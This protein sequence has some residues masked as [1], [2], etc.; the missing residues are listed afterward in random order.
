MACALCGATDDSEGGLCRAC[1]KLSSSFTETL[2]PPE[3]AAA[4]V[5]GDSTGPLLAGPLPLPVRLRSLNFAP[6]EAFGE[7][8]TIVVE[9]GAGGMGQV[10]KALDRQLGRAVALKLIKRDLAARPDSLLRFQRELS[11]AQQVTHG[12]VCRVHDLGEVQGIRYISMEYVEGQTLEDLIRSVIH[13]SPKQMVALGRQICAGLEAIHERGIVHRDLKPGNIMVDRLGHP[14]VM[15]F[16]M[17]YR[18]GGEKLTAAGSV[19]GTL[20]YLSPEHARGFAT[21]PRSDLF[22]LGIIFF[23]MLTGR[24]PPGDEASLPL[25]LRD[26]SETCPPPSRL[27]PEIPPALDAVVL[28][29]LEREPGKRYASARELERALDEVASTLPSSLSVTGLLAAPTPR[30]ATTAPPSQPLPSRA[31]IA[32]LTAAVAVVLAFV[33]AWPRLFPPRPRTTAIALLPLEYSGPEANGYLREFLPVVV[34]DALRRVPEL[35]VAPFASTRGFGPGD[36]ARAVA[37]ALGVEHVVRGTV[38]VEK[39]QV[40]SRLV[41]YGRDGGERPLAPRTSPVGS[42]AETAD[43]LAADLALAVGQTA[44]PT[45]QR[46]AKALELYFEGKRLL[47]GWDVERNYEKAE[48]AF[49]KALEADPSFAEARAALALGLSNH[50]QETREPGVIEQA[51]QEARRAVDLAPGLPEAQLA[52]GVVQVLRGQSAEATASLQRAL[53]LAPGDDAACR[54]IARAY[55][56]RERFEEAE[57][58]F[59]RA[60][61]LRPQFWENHNAMGWFFLRR[62]QNARAR[63]YFKQV[64]EL[65]PLSDTGHINLALSLLW[66]GEFEKAEPFLLEALK[67]GQSYQ[68]HTNLGIVYYNTGRFEEAVREFQ[69]AV[70]AGGTQVESLG[71]LGDALRQV[72]RRDQAKVAYERATSLARD[73]L[74]IDPENGELRAT[75]AMALAG[76]GRCHEARQEAARGA[77]STSVPPAAFSY[78]AVAYAICGD[79]AAAVREAARALDGGA[80]VDVRSNPDLRRVREDPAIRGRLTK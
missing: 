73:Q 17:A 56:R 5:A 53:E 72:G 22:A 3:P 16:G 45:R 57:K 60:I 20:A 59:E 61:A 14:L 25:A 6:G 33:L 44:P 74:R 31:G 2:G 68:A 28:R 29:C 30:P 36:E 19:L 49:K 66:D 32:W 77:R 9:V 27:V 35:Q 34:G 51:S 21:D 1:A 80:V 41:V 79:H 23:E 46:N 55:A 42:A 63:A 67:L 13:L 52:L 12:N 64:I 54:L 24:R 76:D 40:E 48:E 4:Q 15:D 11:L 7:R 8:Y 26:A 43:R 78:A 50:F 10:Y 65:R 62:G 71:G 38:R 58:Y 47:E 39:G 37:R 70:E 69:A 18:P 75:L